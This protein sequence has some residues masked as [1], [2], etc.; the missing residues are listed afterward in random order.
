MNL[1]IPE[2]GDHLLLTEDWKFSL[3]AEGRNSDLAE[4][5]GHYMY[6]WAG[7]WID[8]SV[9]PKMRERDY[10][11]KWDD[12][13]REGE[14]NCP[15]FIKWQEDY[16]LW[17]DNAMSVKKESLAVTIPKGTVLAVDRIYIRKGSSDFSSLTFYAKNLGEIT[18]SQ[19][20]WSG[21]KKVKKKAL[22][23]WA[24]LEDCNTIQFEKTDKIK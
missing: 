7:G 4:F 20:Q 24:K 11:D 13:C 3:H 12:A 6:R 15:E 16:K 19:S 2:I 17:S 18:R 23:L 1:Y 22:R 8:E 10:R 9:L 21:G 14:Q 5:L